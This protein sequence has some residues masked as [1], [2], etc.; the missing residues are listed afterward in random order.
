MKPSEIF[1]NNWFV[2]SFKRNFPFKMHYV[3]FIVKIYNI[4]CI[5]NYKN[6]TNINRQ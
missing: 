2:L 1:T 5:H 4:K 6:T 3:N